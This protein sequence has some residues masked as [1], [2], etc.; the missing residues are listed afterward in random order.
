MRAGKTLAIIIF[1]ITTCVCVFSFTDIPQAQAT[2][3]PQAKIDVTPF[4][5]ER[6]V[7]SVKWDPPWY[8]FFLPAMEAGELEL[9][10]AGIE[11]FRGRPARRI[12]LY[13]RSSGSLAKLANM[14]VEDEFIFYAEPETLCA[15]GGT[16]RIRE[17]KRQRFLELEYF[18]SERKLRFRATDESTT[19]P[20]LQKDVT[21]TDL[22]PCVQ[23]PFSAFYSYR[24]LPLEKNHVKTLIIGNDDKVM[25]VQAK[26]DKQETINTPAGKFNAW[27]ISTNALK[28]GLFQEGGQFHLWI[29]ADELKAIVFFEAKVRLGRVIGTLKSVSRADATPPEP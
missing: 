20:Q 11:E 16:T 7:Y 13:A 19:P 21:K 9:E 8:M 28:G 29:S 18:Q 12:N 27:K 1:I 4:I 2:A 14:K 26:I 23:D 15:E 5:G 25:D 6:L 3:A 17:G 10:F 24:T 22:P